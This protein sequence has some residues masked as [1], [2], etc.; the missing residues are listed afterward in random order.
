VNH[1]KRSSRRHVL[2]MGAAAGAGLLVPYRNALA[3][4]TPGKLGAPLGPYGERSP[5]EKAVRWRRDTKTPE[6]GSSF[7][8]IQDSVGT[9]TPSSLHYERHHSGI[10]SIDP[11]Q[12]R[13][14]IHG[15]VERPLS[16][17]IEEIRRLPSLT[18]ILFLECGGNSGSEWADKTGV[19]VQ[20][21]YGLLSGSEWTG[22]PLSLLLAEVGVKPGARWVIAEG[23]DA[24]RME[25]SI[26]LSKAMDNSLL[27]YG[28]NGEAIR[29]NQGYPLRLINPGWEGN[30]NVKWL[31]SLKVT[32]QPYMARDET[33]KYTELMPDGKAWMFVYEMDAKSVITF[34]SGG[35]ML[36]RRG[37]YELTGLAWSG[38]GRIER[39]EVTL[40]GGRS[41]VNA[42]LHEPRLPIALT[43]F[44]LPW[45]FDGR[46]AVIASRATDDTGY[47]Q[48]TREA[49]IAARG[50]NSNYHFNGMKFWIVRA[51]GTVTNVDA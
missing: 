32:N 30:T 27:A 43:R 14:V 16:L 44:R 33:A 17:S 19:D 26:P 1:L 29:P 34:P 7:T 41:W 48:P 12:H 8:P 50:T 49:L 10:P 47:V 28:Q 21:S 39:V 38:R 23:A 3:L 2:R 5:F 9:L 40:D 22:V 24:C 11:A 45:R 37:P 25:R 51:D 35:Q 31:H 20:R 42:R 13:L 4:D 36:P 15:M 18:R 46:E 6:T